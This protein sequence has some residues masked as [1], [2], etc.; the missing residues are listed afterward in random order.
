MSMFYRE[1]GEF[2]FPD[3][4][5]GRTK[6]AFKDSCDINKILKKAQ[7][8]GG[9]AHVQKYDKAVYGEFQDYDLLEAYGKLERAKQIFADLP[10]EVR[11]EFSN[12]ALAFAGFASDPANIDR[13]AELIPAIAEPGAYFPNP[14]Q[15]GGTGA[16][17]ATAPAEGR[18]A[19]E[20]PAPQGTPKGNTENAPTG[21]T[22]AGGT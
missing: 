11:N 21:A 10:S 18:V 22:E 19:A 5:P 7:K 15:R 8:A 14:R 9:L 13:L 2:Y 16:G 17:A 1:H 4:G 3:F 20:N 6:Q 12:D